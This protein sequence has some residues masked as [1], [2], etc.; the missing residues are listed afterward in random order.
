MYYY[1][2]L[3]SSI[4]SCLSSRNIY[5]SLCISLSCS[6]FSSELFCGE[7]LETFVI[8]SAILFL[9]KSPVTSAVFSVAL[10]EAVLS[11]FADDCLA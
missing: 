4:I 11:A 10:F 3:R 7:V 2:N 9:I 8:P 6:I 5:L 1:I